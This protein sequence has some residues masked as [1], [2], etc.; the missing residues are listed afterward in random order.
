MSGSLSVASMHADS[1]SHLI[2]MWLGGPAGAAVPAVALGE[3]EAVSIG[4]GPS[5]PPSD[6]PTVAEPNVGPDDGVSGSSPAPGR[7]FDSSPSGPSWSGRPVPPGMSESPPSGPSG[8][9]S[10][11]GSSVPGRAWHGS[12]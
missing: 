6:E 4:S 2:S 7:R 8:S 3:P 11:R 9:M 12:P 10:P 1:V 5:R